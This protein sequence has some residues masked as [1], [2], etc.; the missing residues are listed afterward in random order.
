MCDFSVSVIDCPIQHN[1]YLDIH[2]C[3]TL[4]F[5]FV[6]HEKAKITQQGNLLVFRQNE[7]V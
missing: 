2:L 6:F 7:I 4:G 3:S 5:S 1:L